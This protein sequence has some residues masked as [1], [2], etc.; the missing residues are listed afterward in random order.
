M[1]KIL[2]I[3]LV[4]LTTVGLC[5]TAVFKFYKNKADIKADTYYVENKEPEY[6]SEKGVLMCTPVSQ[7]CEQAQ[8]CTY[9]NEL[10]YLYSE[11]G[12]IECDIHNG[13]TTEILPKNDN[14]HFSCLNLYN[15]YIY[16]LN[17]R[18]TP[19]ASLFDEGTVSYEIVRIDYN[20]HETK[21][22]YRAADDNIIGCVSMSYDGMIYFVEGKY[23]ESIK[24]KNGFNDSY[25][26]YS[27][28]SVTL[29]KQEIE[30]CNSY[31]IYDDKLY[32]TKLSDAN[33]TLRLFYSSL[34]DTINSNDTGI[35]VCANVSMGDS[36]MIYPVG[37]YI[38]Y[39][40]T[41]HSL[42]MYDTE[43]KTNEKIIGF[44]EQKRIYYFGIFNGKMIILVREQKPDGFWCYVMYYLD[45][46]NSPV[47]I[48]GDSDFNEGKK[49]WFEYID[50]FCTFPGNDELLVIITYNQ[51]MDKRVYIMNN[52]MSIQMIVQC[53]EW[54]Y[55]AY[56]KMRDGMPEV[57]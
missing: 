11:Q 36:Y 31:Y 9:N 2:V 5:F 48:T 57:T 53:G 3:L 23:D 8:E 42:C 18:Y 22:I 1:K 29:A 33:D 26:L 52:E 45:E 47:R 38:Y 10:V 15:G 56:K 40:D 32:Y 35:D 54:D 6:S 49:Y 34:D 55:D 13:I 16:A 30:K 44:D 21:T 41:D 24:D 28:N 50:G 17:G 4:L 14:D 19:G 20:T 25:T 51:D 12:L 39:T 43:S 7:F 46:M 37:K 27:L